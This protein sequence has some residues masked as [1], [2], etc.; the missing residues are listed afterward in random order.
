MKTRKIWLV[1]ATQGEYSDRREWT[2]AA[3]TTEEQAQTHVVLA[4]AEWREMRVKREEWDE[5]PDAGHDAEPKGI[6]KYDPNLSHDLCDDL[7]G[8][9]EWSYAVEY[10]VEETELRSH[11]PKEGSEQ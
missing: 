2:V 1:R 9:I 3:Y 10:Y 11:A 4:T 6:S 7:P 8:N 5:D